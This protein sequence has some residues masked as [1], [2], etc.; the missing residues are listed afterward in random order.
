MRANV[1][2]IGAM[3]ETQ[4]HQIIPRQEAPNKSHFD[5]L[6]EDN[7]ARILAA[8]NNYTLH[9]DTHVAGT[10]KSVPPADPAARDLGEPLRHEGALGSMFGNEQASET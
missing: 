10:L 8:E 5:G 9:S 4:Q 7:S 1:V 6:I 3:R 2:Y